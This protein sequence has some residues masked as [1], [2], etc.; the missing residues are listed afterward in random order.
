MRRIWTY[1]HFWVISSFYKYFSWTYSHRDY[2]PHLWWCLHTEVLYS[3]EQFHLTVILSVDGEEPFCAGKCHL[4]MSPQHAHSYLL[5]PSFQMRWPLSSSKI[6][7]KGKRVHHLLK[8]RRRGKK[9]CLGEF[10]LSVGFI[11]DH[12]NM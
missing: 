2:C 10:N 9:F 4:S 6:P 7:L 1:S 5:S 3:D 12:T 8:G 11:K